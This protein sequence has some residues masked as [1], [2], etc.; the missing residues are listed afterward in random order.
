MGRGDLEAAAT[1]RPVDITTRFD[2]FPASV[3]GAFVLRGADGNPHSARLLSAEVVRIPAGP[4]KRVSLDDVLLDVA[5]GQDLFIPFEAGLSDLDPG[6]YVVRSFMSVDGG[7]AVKS[8][9]RPFVIP[10]LPGTMRR[11][12]F[13]VGRRLEAADLVGFVERV[14]LASDHATVSWRL[15]DDDHPLG[16]SAGAVL[17]ADGTPLETLPTQGT[18]GRSVPAAA[19]ETLSY[20]VP[21]SCRSLGVRIEVPSGPESVEVQI[22]LS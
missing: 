9:S 20:P 15:E 8:D 1:P 16:A 7:G 11:G 18:A 10:W 14:E 3:K 5:P 4:G 22:P 2:R 21:R 17:V 13:P 19:R 12:V 6:W